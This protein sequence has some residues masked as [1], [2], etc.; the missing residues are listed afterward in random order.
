VRRSASVAKTPEN[1]VG[2]GPVPVQNSEY[3]VEAYYTR[4]PLNGLEA[5]P[6]VRYVIDLSGTGRNRNALVFGL[7]TVVNSW[8]LDQSCI[9]DG[10]L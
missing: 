1:F 2:L 9:V 10:R 3:V 8:A 7:K 6:N 5:R 4:R